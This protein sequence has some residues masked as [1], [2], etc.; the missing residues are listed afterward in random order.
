MSQVLTPD[1]LVAELRSL[2]AR[3]S[4]G[5]SEVHNLELALDKSARELDWAKASASLKVTGTVDEKKNLAE[6]ACAKEREAY[7]L[8]KAA[9]NY[10]KGLLKSL[11]S[12]QMSTMAQ[13]RAVDSTYRSAGRE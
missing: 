2:S 8:A 7:D 4:R 3:I 10:A 11:E 9:F 12:A 13:L 5:V 1:Q 6:M